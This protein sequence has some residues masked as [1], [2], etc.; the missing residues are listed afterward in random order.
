MA[1]AVIETVRSELGLRVPDD[2]SV[3]WRT[4]DNTARAFPNYWHHRKRHLHCRNMPLL[5][6]SQQKTCCFRYHTVER[7]ANSSQ[8]KTWPSCYRCIIKSYDRNIIRN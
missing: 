6:L 8:L 1:I 4:S 7:L 3:V 2:V 5:D